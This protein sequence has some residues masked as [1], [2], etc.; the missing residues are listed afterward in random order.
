MIGLGEPNKLVSRDRVLDDGE[1]RR[2]WLAADRVEPRIGG[3]VK[4]LMLTGQRR[5]EVAGIDCREIDTD[6]ALWRLPKHKAKNAREHLTPLSATALEILATLPRIA[7]PGGTPRYRLHDERQ[8]TG[9][10]LLPLEGRP[11]TPPSS[12]TARAR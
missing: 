11:S 3:F 5:S 1:L 12:R 6:A 4:M 2:I 8:G 10:L 7:A 9:D